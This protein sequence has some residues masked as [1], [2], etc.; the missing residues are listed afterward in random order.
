MAKVVVGTF[1][2]REQAERGA[3]RLQRAGFSRDAISLVSKGERGAEQRQ[4]SMTN[5]GEATGGAMWGAG[6][7]AGAGLLASAGAL[8]I[9]GIGPLI[10]A[11]PL[12]ATLSGAAVGGLAGG[13]ADWG[14]PEERG[15]FYEEEVRAGRVLCAVE[16]D[17]G[18]EDRAEQA[19]REAGAANVEVHQR[20]R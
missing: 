14:I 11:G 12:A 18:E 19:L 2:S 8:A 1:P 13:L 5:L 6:I 20:R 16:A 7:G 10:A 9:P 17:E 4:E 3:E 15:R